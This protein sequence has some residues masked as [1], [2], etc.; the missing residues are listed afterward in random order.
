MKGC[1][2][3]KEIEKCDGLVITKDQFKGL[4]ESKINR[5]ALM[6]SLGRI[7]LKQKKS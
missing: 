2:L 5:K 7:V 1:F 3:T 4:C 6:L